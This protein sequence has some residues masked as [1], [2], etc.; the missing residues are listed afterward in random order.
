MSN[1]AFY[2]ILSVTALILVFGFFV[3]A[4]N[5]MD[6]DTPERAMEI[7]TNVEERDTA[8]PA[9]SAPSI[10][11]S[12]VIERESTVPVPVPSGNTGES[13]RGDEGASSDIGGND[14]A[15]SGADAATTNQ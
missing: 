9:P 15:S 5:R 2:A 7:E 12:R 4:F 11:E 8:L 1:R 13:S 3:F 6:N 14:A 10:I